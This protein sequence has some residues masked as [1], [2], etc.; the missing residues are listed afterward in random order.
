MLQQYI[1]YL[2]CSFSL[3]HELPVLRYLTRC[4]VISANL[5]AMVCACNLIFF[6]LLLFEMKALSSSFDEITMSF[7]MHRRTSG[8]GLLTGG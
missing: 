5:A 2:G 1:R 3:L 8:H 7:N 6:L 4:W